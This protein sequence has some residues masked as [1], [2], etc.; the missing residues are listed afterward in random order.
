MVAF[1]PE[2][3]FDSGVTLLQ[4]AQSGTDHLAAG[5]A[6]TGS[7]EGIDVTGL[8]DRKTD[9]PT[10]DHSLKRRVA[11]EP[12]QARDTTIEGRGLSPLRRRFHRRMLRRVRRSP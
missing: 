6:G 12:A 1:L 10:S 9:G 3:L 11:A 7:D 2:P 8:F 5:S 4:C